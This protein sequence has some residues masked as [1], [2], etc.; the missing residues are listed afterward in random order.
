MKTLIQQEQTEITEMKSENSAPSV[1][2]GDV[3]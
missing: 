1:G 3:V 2:A